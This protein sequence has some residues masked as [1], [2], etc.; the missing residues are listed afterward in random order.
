MKINETSFL[1]LHG[2]PASDFLL[3]LYTKMK[4]FFNNTLKILA[5][6]LCILWIGITSWNWQIRFYVHLIEYFFHN[7]FCGLC[8]SAKNFPWKNWEQC[9]FLFPH[10]YNLHIFG[11]K[12]CLCNFPKLFY[13]VEGFFEAWNLFLNVFYLQSFG[14]LEIIIDNIRRNLK[15][16]QF[17]KIAAAGY[18]C[19][20]RVANKDLGFPWNV[21]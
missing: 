18:K 8:H 11:S 17:G 20:L 4:F 5:A 3:L 21:L 19:N 10:D 12:I 16:M 15:N 14:I 2:F 1:I 7:N 13:C 9:N 6:I